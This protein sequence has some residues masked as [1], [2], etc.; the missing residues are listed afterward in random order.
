MIPFRHSLRFPSSVRIAMIAALGVVAVGLATAQTP[1]APAAQP[2]AEALS[3]NLPIPPAP[4][5]VG[6]PG[7]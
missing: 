6:G 5:V 3:D 7:C 1:Q 4:A 2:A